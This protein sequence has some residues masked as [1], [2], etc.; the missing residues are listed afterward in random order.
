[1]EFGHRSD[2]HA[3]VQ[4]SIRDVDKSSSDAISEECGDGAVQAA[5]NGVFTKLTGMVTGV[6]QSQTPWAVVKPSLALVVRMQK[7]AFSKLTETLTR[8]VQKRSPKVVANPARLPLC[9]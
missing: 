8:V 3:C 7:G 9:W 1:M 5:D 4:Q 6:V 2:V